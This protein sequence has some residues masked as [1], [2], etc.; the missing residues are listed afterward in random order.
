[1]F[2]WLP[3]ATVSAA[4]QPSPPTILVV[5]DSI[6]AAYGMSLQEGWVA[7]LARRLAQAQPDAVVFNAS[8]SGDTTDNA[9]RRLP[10]LLEKHQPT[11][12]IIEVGGNDGLRGFPIKQ[13]RNNLIALCEQSAATGANVLLLRMKIPPNYGV[14][15]TQGFHQAFEVAAQESPCTLGRF[16]LDGVATNTE[17]MQ[18]DGIHPT[19]EAQPLLLD[20][21]WPDIMA[22]LEPR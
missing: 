12:V 17:F 10:R 16:I 14:T 4:G 11:G 21:V 22:F 9:L 7:L 20:N 15:Y 3:V 5:G 13:I 2:L 18:N 19:R 6:S 8:I 1:M